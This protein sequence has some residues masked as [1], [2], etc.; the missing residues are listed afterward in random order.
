MSAFESMKLLTNKE[1]YFHET[2]HNSSLLSSSVS[3]LQEPKD[4]A[5]H[6]G[7]SN[8]AI[9]KLDLLGKFNVIATFNVPDPFPFD[10]GDDSRTNLFKEGGNDKDHNAN[11]LV[12]RVTKI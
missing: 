12:D 2:N 9:S 8:D 3:L 1:A 6:I 11:D 5:T 4:Y 7:K 10:I